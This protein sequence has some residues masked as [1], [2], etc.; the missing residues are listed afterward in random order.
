[1]DKGDLSRVNHLKSIYIDQEEDERKSAKG[2]RKRKGKEVGRGEEEGSKLRERG[3]EGY[4]GLDKE[5]GRGVSGQEIKDS[6]RTTFKGSL[7]DI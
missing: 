1:M 4:K 7:K 2:T 6:N 3:G 5:V